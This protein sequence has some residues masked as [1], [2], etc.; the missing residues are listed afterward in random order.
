MVVFNSRSV[1]LGEFWSGRLSSSRMVVIQF[2]EQEASVPLMMAKVKE[3]LRSSEEIILTDRNGVLIQ[4]EQEVLQFKKK[5]KII[6]SV[7]YVEHLFSHLHDHL[8][9]QDFVVL[10]QCDNV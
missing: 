9:G 4:K 7:F 5:K 3:A 2:M 10:Q 1:S 6:F 8:A